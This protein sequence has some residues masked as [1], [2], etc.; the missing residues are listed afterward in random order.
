VQIVKDDAIDFDKYLQAPPE[1]AQIKPASDWCQD[2]INRFYDDEMNYQT[3]LPWSKTHENI[4]LRPGEVTIWAGV[5]GHGKSLILNH[6]M[7]SVMDQSDKVCIASM[8]M[9]PE[10][11]LYRMT[12]QATNQS[13]P[14]IPY[15]RQFHNWTDNKLW[16]YDHHGTVKMDRIIAVMRYASEELHIQHFVIDSLMKCGINTDDYNNQKSFIDQ[17]CAHAKDTGTHVHLVAHARK[18][19]TETQ[20][21]DKF[22]VK[23]A[24]EITDQ[25]DNVFTVWRNKT[26]EWELQRDTNADLG[27]EPDCVLTCSKQR[28]GEWEGKIPLWFDQKSMQYVESGDRA[29]PVVYFE[30]QAER[31][32]IQ[33]EPDML[34]DMADGKI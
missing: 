20:A 9:K 24:S 8:E 15:I 13:E 26:K 6:I 16:I 31:Q 21:V 19:V 7:L 27:K 11:T 34:Q 33:N 10:A 30:A 1:A 32:A 5:N 17:L 2:V 12:R 28:H 22:D 3:R 29:K 25:V 14:A 18:G 23:G 4:R